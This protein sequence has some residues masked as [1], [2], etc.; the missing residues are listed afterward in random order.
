[1]TS[2][3]FQILVPI[4]FSQQSLA[5][6]HQAFRIAH[7]YDASITLLHVVEDEAACFHFHEVKSRTALLEKIDDSLKEIVKSKYVNS[8]II[9]S[10][11]VEFGAVA[12]VVL[13]IQNKENFPM[14]V[15]GFNELKN[16]YQK[17]IGSNAFKVI[18]EADCQV[19]AVKNNHDS[20]EFKSIILPLDLSKPLEGKVTKAIEL[21]RSWK[22]SFVTVISILPVC[23]DLK[24]NVA[25]HQLAQIVK[26]VEKNKVRC[27]AEIIRRIRGREST[28]EIIADYA[29]R[30][31]CE[32][33]MMIA[34]KEV[35]TSKRLG[36][37]AQ[38]IMNTVDI[39]VL[40]IVPLVNQN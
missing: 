16:P 24:V 26:E 3:K 37:A 10:C 20:D 5:V 31:K 21:A 11:R 35:G 36:N 33:V 6:F 38:S 13:S 32:M 17:L 22:G 28:A 39:P 15:M 19:I 2:S 34:R 29:H 7:I 23:D 30:V 18:K 1:M 25:T 9:V 12:D 14:I 27:N 4:D 8:K 40:S